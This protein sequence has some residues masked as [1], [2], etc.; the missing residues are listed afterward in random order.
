MIYRESCK[1]FTSYYDESECFMHKNIDL[2]CMGLLGDISSIPFASTYFN[3]QYEF[4]YMF[5]DTSFQEDV[6]RLE[7]FL[8]IQIN[9]QEYLNEGD[10]F[11]LN[12]PMWLNFLER[13]SDSSTNAIK[14]GANLE[15]YF[16]HCVFN[17]Y[18]SMCKSGEPG[19]TDQVKK[20][21]ATKQF[22]CV[23]TSNSLNTNPQYANFNIEILELEKYCKTGFKIDLS[24]MYGPMTVYEFGNE[25]YIKEVKSYITNPDKCP[26]FPL[27][28][29]WGLTT[30]IEPEKYQIFYRDENFSDNYHNFRGFV[31]GDDTKIEKPRSFLLEKETIILSWMIKKDDKNVETQF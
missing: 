30:N 11:V 1:M 20:I 15:F 29:D 5:N 23:L 16:T 19:C 25:S 22:K 18:K 14:N 24:K 28:G 21:I 7:P 13:L 12:Q 4:I 17:Y 10:K 6:K 31:L 8:Q 26:G 27:K 3:N 9:T 2:C